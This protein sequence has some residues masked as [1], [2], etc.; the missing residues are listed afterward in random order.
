[1]WK[2]WKQS[3]F[4]IKLYAYTQP[5]SSK[6][7]TEFLMFKNGLLSNSFCKK[8]TKKEIFIAY[9]K[10]KNS[11]ITENVKQSRWQK[12]AN[13]LISLSPFKNSRIDRFDK[14]KKKYWKFQNWH[15]SKTKLLLKVFYRLKKPKK[16]RKTPSFNWFSLGLTPF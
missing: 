8:L 7:T 15:F 12:S 9:G 1:M 10:Q 11:R 2:K 16:T 13:I 3:G 4:Q 6:S 5:L 14:L